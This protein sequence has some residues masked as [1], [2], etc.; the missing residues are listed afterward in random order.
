MATMAEKVA[1]LRTDFGLADGTPLISVIEHGKTQLGDVSLDGPI[2]AQV[3]KLYDQI[4]GGGELPQSSGPPVVQGVVVVDQGVAVGVPTQASSMPPANMPSTLLRD[5]I[6]DAISIGA[7]V[8]NDGD[9]AG[10]YFIYMRTVEEVLARMSHQDLAV[11]LSTAASQAQSGGGRGVTRAAWTMR[12]VMDEAKDGQ[13]AR[14]AL[15]GMP[16]A[17]AIWASRGRSSIVSEASATHVT[18]ADAPP[19]ER[20]GGPRSVK[21]AISGAIRVG[22]PTY[23]AGNKAGCYYIYMRTAEEMARHLG[24]DE[25]TFG[26]SSRY[27]PTSRTLEQALGQAAAVGDADGAAWVMR[28]CFDNL[29][30]R[31]TNARLGAGMPSARALCSEAGF[32]GRASGGKSKGCVVA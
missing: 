25:P 12:R 16:S 29:S 27:P 15:P 14:A 20:G 21:E 26:G 1:A 8:Y 30:M 13:H 32:P 23:N 9:H 19:V 5:A 24:A 22:A 2:A 28:R 3:D 17:Q 18:Q 31:P 10:C 11:A 6:G 4:H 7:P